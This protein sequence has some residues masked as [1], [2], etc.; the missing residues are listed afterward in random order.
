MLGEDGHEPE[1]PSGGAGSSM[2][3]QAKDVVQAHTVSGG[4][5][6]HAAPAGSSGAAPRQLP[7]DVRGFVNREAD[8]EQVDRILTERLEGVPGVV[9][10]AGT[11]GVGKTSLAVRWAHRVKDRFPD[12]Q[13]YINLRGYDPGAPVEA[14]HALEQL[15]AALHTPVAEIPTGLEARSALFRSL[16]AGRRILVV[17]DNAAKAAQV[18]P[19]LPGEGSSLTLVTSRARISGLMSRDGARCVTLDVFPENESVALLRQTTLPY[20]GADGDDDFR[21]L[22]RLCANLPLALRI[23]AERA[24]A[25]PRMPLTQ[26]IAQLR[27]DEIWDALSSD[28]EE[29]ADA[30]RAVFAWSYRA[31]TQDV[32][33]MFRLLGV[34]AGPDFSAGAAAALAG[35]HADHGRRLLDQLVRCHLVEQRGEDRFQFHDLLRA[36]AIDQLRHQESEQGRT[37][38]LLRELDWYV[39]SGLNASTAA[40]SIVAI[41]IHDLPPIDREPQTFTSR[42]EAVG[43]YDR[44]RPSIL[45]AAL[46]ATRAGLYEKVWQ[47]A[48]ATYPVAYVL[49]ASFDDSLAL[50]RLGLDA[51]VEVGA[52]QAEAAILGNLGVTCNMS[53]R[54][55]EAEA[56]HLRSL[57]VS[58]EIGDAEQETR[59]T[60]ALGWV[61][62]ANRRLAEAELQFTA[63]HES[64]LRLTGQGRKWIPVALV[65]RAAACLAQERWEVAAELAEKALSAHSGADAEPRLRFD[66]QRWLAHIRTH[67][68][69][70]DEAERLLA[71]ADESALQIGS[72][73]YEGIVAFERG[74]LALAGAAYEDSLT[75]F[76][77]GG[78]IA[79]SVADRS[80]EA[81]TYDGIGQAYRGLGRPGE[82][83]D[84]HRRAAAIFRQMRDRW[85]QA[86]ALAHLGDVLEETG[87]VESAL[88]C[89]LESL[90]LISA[91]QDTVAVTLRSRLAL[92]IDLD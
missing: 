82:A 9:L 84:F 6:F 63:T 46:A 1:P 79:N 23:A 45:A 73:I 38:A 88:G 16:V 34:H 55:D 11:A 62:L 83:A 13:L 72:Q 67:L 14:T 44:E 21:R 27:D 64:A 70:F 66:V 32:A 29:E 7:A 40:Q 2:S 89:R 74:I 36:Y 4:V 60:N 49:R 15:L 92:A 22:A 47:L 3:G 20:R 81:Q 12:G 18:R 5:H 71:G 61:Y 33:R 41:P 65:N 42:N 90:E 54:Q 30:V 77:L 17:L 75:H 85:R 80:L 68:G 48:A 50:G 52:R 76:H 56:Y 24:A 58:R 10:I 51:A 86:V 78:T 26:L 31:L 87:D 19:L 37:D 59:N 39:R 53:N 8:L 28:D 91:Y 35:V 25:R 57:Q 43:W 69:A